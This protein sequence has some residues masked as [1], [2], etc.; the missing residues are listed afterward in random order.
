MRITFFASEGLPKIHKKDAPLR[1][2][3]SSIGSV[4]YDTAK[5]LAKIMK[6]LVGLNGHHIVNSEDFVNKIAELEVPPGQ[7]LVSYDVSALFTS[8][9]INEAISV[10]KAKLEGDSSLPDR[11]PLDIT[12]LSTL[13]EMCLSST[14]FTYQHEFYK[15]KQGAAMGSPISPIVANLYMEQFESRALDTA[16]T[17]PTMWYRYVDDT[18]AKIHEHA[19]DSFSDHL[20][21]IDQHIQ[22]TSEQEKEGKIPFLD[23]CVHVNQ[24]GST[25]ISVYR[26]PTHTDQYLNFHS[27]HHLQHK[28]AVVNTLML[29]AQTLVT[30]DEDKTREAQ[31][32]K[33]ALKVNNYPDW[34]LTIP[35]SKSGTKEPENEKKIYASAPYI[36]GISERLQRA[37]KSHDRAKILFVLWNDSAFCSSLFAMNEIESILAP[38]ALE[39]HTTPQKM[40]LSFKP[41]S[42]IGTAHIFSS[43]I[44]VGY[45]DYSCSPCTIFSVA[46][47]DPL[48]VDLLFLFCLHALQRDTFGSLSSDFGFLYMVYIWLSQFCGSTWSGSTFS[49]LFT[50][51]SMRHIWLSRITKTVLPFSK[52]G[53]DWIFS[54][55]KILAPALGFLPGSPGW[56]SIHLT[57]AIS[58]YIC[59]KEEKTLEMRRVCCIKMATMKKQ[60]KCKSIKHVFLYHRKSTLKELINNL[61]LSRCRLLGQCFRAGKAERI[62]L[63]SWGCSSYTS[64]YDLRRRQK[65]PS[66]WT[67]SGLVK[68]LDFLAK[69]LAPTFLRFYF[70]GLV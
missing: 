21:S 5:F 57:G 19:V 50:C 30:E 14:Y 59:V 41:F 62:N 36:K 60:E 6:P 39:I 2:I 58:G 42:K 64:P 65:G 3:V 68:R 18:M 47:V 28:R 70:T 34:M 16:P 52:F 1:P 44:C 11:C 37:F 13:L 35:H 69:S 12:Q 46:L 24:D 9:P 26:K 56:Q 63:E 31:H 32:V 27:N 67:K 40:L 38:V 4:M 8:I 54:R 43:T 15:Q 7:K 17:P 49:F 66:M 23:T 48:G 29:R 33:Q 53:T 10:T 25:K 22:F 61:V 51:V 55:Q 45:F 20:N